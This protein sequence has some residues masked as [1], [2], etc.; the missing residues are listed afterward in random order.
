MLDASPLRGVYERA[1]LLGLIRVVRRQ[2][3]RAINCL[4]SLIERGRLIEVADRDMHTLPA[5]R[6]RL[7]HVAHERFHGDAKVCQLQDNF[8]AG[9]AG[10]A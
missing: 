4:E 2:Q 5:K 9:R 1:L 7:C 8:F 6:R 10:G 3:Q